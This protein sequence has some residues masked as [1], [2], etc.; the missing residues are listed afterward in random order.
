MTIKIINF[1]LQAICFFSN[2]WLLQYD[3]PDHAGTAFAAILVCLLQYH[4]GRIV[5]VHQANQAIENL[6]ESLQNMIEVN[7]QQIQA[8]K[9][10]I[11]QREELMAAIDRMRSK[12]HFPSHYSN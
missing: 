12:T 1:T 2:Y 4:I 7:Q 9:T 5:A 10:L 3:G 6:D 11:A 8:N